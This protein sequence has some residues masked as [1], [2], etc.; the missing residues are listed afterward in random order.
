MV[1]D[2]TQIILDQ[3]KEIRDDQKDQSSRL[4]DQNVMIKRNTVSLEEHIRRT[5]I[6]E[7]RI[8]QLEENELT[9]P[10]KLELSHRKL[11]I[12][13]VKDWSIVLGF[14]VIVVSQ[15]WPIVKSLLQ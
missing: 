5:E 3:L 13:R 10:A 8:D 15:F 14:V 4:Y 7:K 9:C 2:V 12:S 1:D 11:F 6:A